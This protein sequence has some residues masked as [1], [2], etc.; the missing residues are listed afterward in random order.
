MK[1]LLKLTSLL[2]AGVIALA[3]VGVAGALI[4]RGQLQEEVRL[5]TQIT[6]PDG[7]DTL[8]TV[9]LG[10]TQQWI[11]L[12]GHDRANPV[13]LFLHG[14]PGSPEMAA[15]R[16]FGLEVEEHFTVV[17]WDQRASGKSRRE[18][19]DDA[20]LTLAQYLSD[21]LE[22][23][24]HLRARFDQDKI[25][26]VGHSWGSGLGV[27]A[28]RDHPELLHAYVG[29]GQIVNM[30]ENEHLSWEFTMEMARQEGNDE[31]LRELEGLKPPYTGNMKELFIQRKWLTHFGGAFYGIT[32]DELG[33]IMWAS[34][35]YSVLDLVAFY[36]GSMD[37]PKKMW[38]EVG[39]IDF[40][41]QA[42][43]LDVPVYFFTG[44]HDYNA[45]FELAE[46][47]YETL[48]APHKEMVWFENSG[49]FPNLA[50]ADRY[51]TMLIE[52]VLAET[53]P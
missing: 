14:G 11:H 31:A 19:Y 12:R 39:A 22:L 27:L 25:Y 33:E 8:E 15:G 3:L 44:R 17:H 18:K 52:K 29:I 7:I 10:G 2:L 46:R 53:L 42:P 37:V 24:N 26:L 38:S 5:A 16:A 1:K 49:H 30:V 9:T 45:P 23:I 20:S 40:F 6:T 4:W 36:R 32:M 34:P 21:T 13:L 35:E 41:T 47:Y 50:E 48:E 51:Q 28:A 43:K